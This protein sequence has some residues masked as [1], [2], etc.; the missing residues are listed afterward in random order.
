MESIDRDGACYSCPVR[1]IFFVLRE[2]LH[3]FCCP[4]IAF[5]VY[6][7]FVSYHWTPGRDGF[8]LELNKMLW[9]ELGSTV[10]V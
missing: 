8:L 2:L 9:A 10:N 4:V 5:G 6:W 7:V 3:I 1:R